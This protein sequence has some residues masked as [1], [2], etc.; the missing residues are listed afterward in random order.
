M[1]EM[2][3][4]SPR[5]WMSSTTDVQSSLEPSSLR[6]ACVSSIW[7]VFKGDKWSRLYQI[8]T[9][10]KLGTE[11]ETDRCRDREWEPVSRVSRERVQSL[12]SESC[13]LGRQDLSMPGCDLWLWGCCKNSFCIY[14][15]VFPS[16]N[17]HGL[18]NS[19]KSV[20]KLRKYLRV[21]QT[22]TFPIFGARGR[23]GETLSVCLLECLDQQRARSLSNER[24]KG[25]QSCLLWAWGI[26]PL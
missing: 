19:L 9:G 18:T 16:C 21:N 1:R 26:F 25:P 5:T 2:F 11:R 20:G 3:D 24:L 6:C 13:S 7:F 4:I 12:L 17:S 14:W 8:V 23:G 10:M 15:D 22:R